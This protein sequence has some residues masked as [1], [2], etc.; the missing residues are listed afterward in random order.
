MRSMRCTVLMIGL[1]AAGCGRVMD[2]EQVRLCRAIIPVLNAEDA[3]I[4]E[5]RLAPAALGRSGV[6][7]DY[8]ARETGAPRRIHFV[9]CGFGGTSFERDRLDLTM[10]ETETGPLGIAR[11]TFLKR[12]LT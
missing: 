9:T 7:I 12:Y 1:V 10:V 5:L 8:A 3:E 11:L 2:S 4:R 6:R